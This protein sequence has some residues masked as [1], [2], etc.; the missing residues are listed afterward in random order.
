VVVSL[1]ASWQVTQRAGDQDSKT[2]ATRRGALD[3]LHWMSILLQCFGIHY[4]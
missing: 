1:Q 4:H 2:L 3:H